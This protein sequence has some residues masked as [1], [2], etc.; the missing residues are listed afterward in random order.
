MGPRGGEFSCL[1]GWLR[2]LAFAAGAMIFVVT[3]DLIPEAQQGGHAD[4]ATIGLL[5]GF[6]LMMVL[7]VALG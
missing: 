2:A 7:D 1:T 3:E 6:A 4:Q 5:I